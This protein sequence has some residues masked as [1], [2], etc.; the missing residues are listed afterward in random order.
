MDRRERLIT[1][2]EDTK[3][4]YKQ[5]PQLAKAVD[6]S[7][8]AT[9][10]YEAEDY[11]AGLTPLESFCDVE[12]TKQKSFEAAMNIRSEH[13]DWKIAV[14]NFASATNPG[15]GVKTGSSAQEESLCRCSTLYPTLVQDWL[16]QCY[17]G[18]NRASHDNLHTDACIY[19]PGVIICKTDTTWPERMEEK[20]WVK[21]DIISC[22]APNL[23]RK[24]GNVHNPEYGRA[25]TISAEEL[26]RLHRKRANHILHVAAAN[27]VDAIILGAFGCGVFQL[28]PELVAAYFREVLQENEFR[29]KFHTVVFAL[30]EGKGSAR[31]KV[32]E[33]GDFAPF[34]Q[35]FGRFE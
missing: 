10:L 14:L 26:Y 2:F 4:F 25:T 31:K 35:Q 7:K 24:P 28:K 11:P 22:A 32:E 21:V 1:I 27:H 23:R 9:R 29:G 34:Y 16:W 18:K 30:L 17:Y 15:G 3:Q 20:D 5:N 19:S 12:V 13:P 33:E 8:T 6:E